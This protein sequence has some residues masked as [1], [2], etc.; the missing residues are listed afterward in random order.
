MKLCN[1]CGI[2]KNLAEFH[3]RSD[4]AGGAQ[5]KCKLCVKEYCRVNADEKHRQQA[6]YYQENKVSRLAKNKAWKVAN[7]E[8]V[9]EKNKAY[10]EN[11][12]EEMN[13]K[14]SEYYALNRTEILVRNAQYGKDN[15]EKIKQY[16]QAWNKENSVEIAKRQ[17]AYNK[18]NHAKVVA[19]NQSWRMANSEA[20]RAYSASRRAKE[21]AAQGKHSAKD[22]KELLILQKNKCA[23]CACCIKE[24]YHVDHKYAIH[25]GGANDKSNLQI[26]C[27][28]CNLSKGSKDPIVF[29]QSRGF[30]I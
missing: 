11:N 28:S 17:A 2:T 20:C 1:T 25:T 18:I 15:F 8:R 13:R 4:R 16:R 10:Y 21:R 19:G 14:S 29:M 9:L 12:K 5:S 24:K 22:I 30:L 23:V 27:Q 3:K 7:R 6:I 26:L